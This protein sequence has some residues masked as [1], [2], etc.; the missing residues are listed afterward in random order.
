MRNEVVYLVMC[1]RDIELLDD[2]IA[3]HCAPSRSKIYIT[4]AL[5][6]LLNLQMMLS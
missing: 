6:D 4:W 3:D 5:K 1:S 2:V